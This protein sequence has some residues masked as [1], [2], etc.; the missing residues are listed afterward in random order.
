LD[1]KKELSRAYQMLGATKMTEK[2]QTSNPPESFWYTFVVGLI[3]LISFIAIVQ[4]AYV[5]KIGWLFGK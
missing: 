4:F 5:N 3:A 2:K 1:W